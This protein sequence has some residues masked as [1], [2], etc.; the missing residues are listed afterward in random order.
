MQLIFHLLPILKVRV[1]I[2]Y[3]GT[4]LRYCFECA[5]YRKFYIIILNFIRIQ[6]S[7]TKMTMISLDLNMAF[8]NMTH[9]TYDILYT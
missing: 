5:I 2:I 8:G 1:N 6:I 4:D 9:P 7:D 3:S